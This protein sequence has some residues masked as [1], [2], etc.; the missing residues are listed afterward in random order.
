MPIS[1]EEAAQMRADQAFIKEQIT[2]VVEALHQNT[3]VS[4]EMLIE[5][6]ERDVRDEYREKEFS[7]LKEAVK[8]VD[9]KIDDYI[10]SE[11]QVIDWA[12]SRKQFYDSLLKGMTSTWGKM[13]GALIIIV[14]FAAIGIDLT[15]LKIG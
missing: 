7:E 13:A 2:H 10:E 15:K 8:S 4:G 3:K 5:M 11:K 1:P 6:R 12:R 9:K 14:F